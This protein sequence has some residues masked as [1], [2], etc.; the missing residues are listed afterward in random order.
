MD[1]IGKQFREFQRKVEASL[2]RF[3]RLAAS[4]AQ[5]FFLDSFKHQAWFGE[6]T[7]VWKPRKSRSKK[8]AGRALL[9]QKGRL[10]RSIRIKKADWNSVVVGSDVPYAAVHNEG[11][12]GRFSRTATRK[13]KVRG[14]Y[15]KLGDE[16]KRRQKMLIAG[17]THEV[18]QNIP[19]RRF[20]GNSPWLNK[21]IE[22]VFI[23]E[24]SK[25]K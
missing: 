12:R 14:S 20:M 2:K 24:L 18:K 25:I 3:P 7:E 4:E 17:V 22:R 21:R 19:R 5:N 13:V 15:S 6:T 9:V 1:D 11:F 16:R 8:N 10:R 23:N